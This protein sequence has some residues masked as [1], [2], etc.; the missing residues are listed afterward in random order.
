MH[1]ATWK[2][3]IGTNIKIFHD[4]LPWQ[5][6]PNQ[7]HSN[8][9]EQMFPTFTT[10]FD[11]ILEEMQE[12]N[13]SME[14]RLVN[15][16]ER[17]KNWRRSK[18]VKDTMPMDT[19]I[20]TQELSRQQH[21]YIFKE[22]VC[23][24]STETFCPGSDETTCLGSKETTCP[25]SKHTFYPGS[26]EIVCLSITKRICPSGTKRICTGSKQI[27]CLEMNNM[28]AVTTTASAIR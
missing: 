25:G 23:P 16:D 24:G 12:L 11:R 9:L 27:F 8:P 18:T 19:E 1:M 22:T 21:G 13:K 17:M 28:T 6:T 4:M 15:M 2:I 3:K 26:E 14:A 5:Y 10:S 20:P 7:E